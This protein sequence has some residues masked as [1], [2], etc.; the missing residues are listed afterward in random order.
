MSL[1]VNPM[2]TELELAAKAFFD[3]LFPDLG[4]GLIEV[5]SIH[6][7]DRD[8]RSKFYNSIDQLMYEFLG[9]QAL[10]K[11]FNVYFGVCPR[12]RKEG[13]KDAVREVRCLWVDL[14]A[15]PAESGKAQALTRLKEFPI[16]PTVIVD[17][18]NGYHAYWVLKEPETEKKSVELYL[19]GL[20]SALGGDKSSCEVARVLRFPG[21]NNHKNPTNFLPVRIIQI[22]PSRAYNLADFDGFIDVGVERT[23]ETGREGDWVADAL[24]N[25]SNGNRNSTFASI[26]GRLHRDGLPASS[27]KALLGPH[28]ERCQ[29]PDDELTREVEGICNRYP[30]QDLNS[31][32]SLN[33]QAAFEK[34][35]PDPLREE[36]FHG[37]V[38]EIVRKI[39]PHTESDPAALLVQAMVV[40]GNVI[41]RSAHFMAEADRHY[42]NIFSVVVGATSKGRKGTSFGHIKRLFRGIDPTWLPDRIP[43]GL[44]SGEG[45]I[46][47][48]RDKIEKREPIDK[49]KLFLGYQNIEI[50]AG[51][52]DKRLLVV[53]AEFASPLR[54]IGREGNTLSALMRQAWDTGTLET[55]T[56]NSPAKATNAHISIVGH[57]TRDELC[58]YLDKTETANGFG[59]RFLWVCT[60]RSKMLPE[61]GRLHDEDIAPIVRRLKVAVEH[62]K[63]VTEI[64]RDES[65]RAYWH[66]L[67]VLLSKEAPGLVG[68]MTARSEAQVMR[69]ACIYALFDATNTIRL[70]HLKA[71]LAVWDYCAESVRYIFGDGLGDPIADTI[72]VSLRSKPDGLSRTEISKLFQRHVESS[73]ITRALVL[74]QEVGLAKEISVKTPGRSQEVWVA[75]AKEANNAK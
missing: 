65:A 13:T 55:L 28:A 24:S 42:L 63:T 25:L 70:E 2:D 15:K 6:P 31:H 44:S 32:I 7:I 20:C 8:V 58:R 60:K 53:E 75:V 38:G 10:A 69:L 27:I 74:L 9:M 46:W 12:S 64:K 57:I 68:A 30:G 22:D 66:E 62:G 54:I 45:L 73:Q 40:F 43:S 47:A 16:Q 52:S 59:N 39:E 14:D 41:G 71:G 21:T 4:D 50:D 1:S 18:G 72:L 33:S 35:W 36:A 23:V 49:K 67:Y 17:S 34:K 48:V 26:I 37:L 51:V 5:R 61:G 11:S 3:V 56:K 29:F 19:R